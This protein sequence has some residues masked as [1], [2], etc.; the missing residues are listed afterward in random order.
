M[1]S[2]FVLRATPT[3]VMSVLVPGSMPIPILWPTALVV[4]K[5]FVANASFTMH[6]LGDVSV[7]VI[8]KSRPASSVISIVLK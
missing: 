4:P 5:Y 7:S 6:T 3:I 2:Y 8:R 1:L